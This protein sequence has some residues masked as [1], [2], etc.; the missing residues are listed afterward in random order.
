M[1]RIAVAATLLLP[2]A[3]LYTRTVGDTLLSTVAILFLISRWARHDATWLRPLH[4]RL[5]LIFW[6]WEL[7]CTL[8]AGRPHEIVEAL[9]L[10]RLFLFAAALEFWLLAGSTQRRQLQYVI[11]AIA[12][13]IVVETWQQY[14]LG[15]NMFGYPR[16]GSGVL[17]GPL[18]GPRAGLSLQTIYFAAFLPPATALIARPQWRYR[19]AGGAVLIAS[20]LTMALIGQ[21]M[22]MLLVLCGYGITALVLRSFRWP[23]IMAMLAL[24]AAIAVARLAA[25]QE[26]HTLVVVF[27]HRMANFWSEPYAI[28]YQRAIVIIQTHPWLGLGFDGYRDNCFDPRYIRILSWIPVTD[29]H[30]SIACTIHPHN[31]WL[32]IASDS[33]LI[34]VALF[35]A[36]C[37][38][39]LIRIARFMQA[40]GRAIQVG[41]FVSLCIAFWPIASTTGLFTLPNA[42]WLFL[43]I[44]WGLA[45]RQ[46]NLAAPAR[47]GQ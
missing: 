47:T 25:P 17:T 40:P 24:G 15:T 33:G 2:P 39:W 13:W 36:L 26:Y 11:V 19:L 37:I 9:V 30:E 38:A 35:A 1:F 31:Y 43:L 5:A 18:P 14:A 16:W 46:E 44:G 3:L 27:L 20:M 32:Q 21:R 45:E 22:P 41:L 23:M 34:G 12:V 4:V 7:I 28:I 8:I 29:I 6:A 42:G 10:I